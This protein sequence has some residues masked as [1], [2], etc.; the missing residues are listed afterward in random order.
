MLAL[1]AFFGIVYEAVKGMAIAMF[2]I[3]YTVMLLV[4]PDFEVGARYLVPQLLVTGAFAIRGATVIGRLAGGKLH[5][6]SI[7]PIGTA[8][9]AGML[10]LLIVLSPN[11]LPSGHWDFGVTGAPTQEVFAFIRHD[12]PA[13]A[14]IAVSPYRSFHLFT[15]RTTIRIPNL[16]TIPDFIHWIHNYGVTAVV[17]KYPSPHWTRDPVD[18]PGSVLCRADS[19]KSGLSEVFRNSIYAVFTINASSAPGYQGPCDVI[20]GGCAEAYSVTRAMTSAYSGSLFQLYNGSTFQDVGQ[21]SAHVADLSTWQS[22]CGGSLSSADSYGIQ[23][24]T[25]PHCTIT[26]IYAQIHRHANDLQYSLGNYQ[27]GNCLNVGLCAATMAIEAA[28]NLPIIEVIPGNQAAAYFIGGGT[29]NSDTAATGVTGGS[30]SPA[31][32]MYNGK[33]LT[34]VSCCG[35]FGLTHSISASDTP[36]TDFMAVTGYGW[37]SGGPPVGWAFIACQTSTTYCAGSENESANDY[38]DYGSTLY[39]NIVVG[40]MWNPS[41]GKGGTVSSYVNS[42]LLFSHNPPCQQ[43]NQSGRGCPRGM[44][45]GNHI[46]AVAG[47]DLSNTSA[48]MRE[49]LITNTAISSADHSAVF[50]NMEA[51]YRSL[52]FP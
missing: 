4:L 9:L 52:S 6:K 17:I 3:C 22:F 34:A 23:R 46:H 15:Q 33:P 10:C 30:S 21:T 31:S 44:N 39:P 27:G 29:T 20:A 41:L 32:I 47:G 12:L 19:V 49:A 11:P 2:I 8:G 35:Q 25:A 43:S 18:C 42:S 7:L 51:F 38:I 36:G 50:A 1:L 24:S 45:L 37:Y 40:I 14:V 13:D 5:G 16:P 28:T 48:I 26:A